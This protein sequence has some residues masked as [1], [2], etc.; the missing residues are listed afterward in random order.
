MPLSGGSAYEESPDAIHDRDAPT[1]TNE[2]NLESKL[3]KTVESS[4]IATDP[5]ESALQSDTIFQSEV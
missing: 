2:A 1:K 5:H 3:V 4:N